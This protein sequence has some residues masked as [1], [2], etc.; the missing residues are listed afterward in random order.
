MAK[1]AADV[2]TRLSLLLGPFPQKELTLEP[3]HF[4]GAP[5]VARVQL[6]EIE[7]SES[8]FRFAGDE[9]LFPEALPRA[10]AEQW[11]LSDNLIKA[12]DA[13]LVRALGAY[14]AWRY[15]LET[16]PAAAQ[17]I[18]A[19]ATRDTIGDLAYPLSD[20]RHPRGNSPP[21][22]WIVRNERGMLVLRTL[23]TAIDRER[24]DRVI[25]EMM[26]RAA[27]RPPSTELLEAVCEEVAKRKLSWFFDYFVRG[28]QIPTIE[29]RRLASESPNVVA[30][31]I[32]V[33]DFPT[34]GSLRVEMAVRTAQGIV[35]H[36][37]ATHGAVTPF[38]VN[39]PAP[40]QGIT[41]DPDLRILRWTDA[42]RRSKAQ[43]AILAELPN[44]LTKDSLGAAIE[45]YRR[46][47]AADA[48]DESRRAQSLRERLGEL[49][50]AHGDSE[51]ALADLEAAINGHSI[52]AFETYLCRAK[53][54]LYHGVVLL[55]LGRAKEAR[56]DARAGLAL[57][58]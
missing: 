28:R 3:V 6:G 47:L 22:N 23:E 31:E 30:G 41:L 29:L 40:A 39:V 5:R 37:V 38:T 34:E 24:V 46:A 15:L 51:A 26:H 16:N 19:E 45:V 17:V 18:V 2:I 57:P 14:A 43:I 7:A 55:H 1:K 27:G 25:P 35:E 54:Y 42:A 33:K 36:S 10:I 20:E 9:N 53:A 49:E 13:W 11:L 8:L 50:W 44:P 4:G 12:K 52:A 48:D 58:R 32:V 56:E 21:D